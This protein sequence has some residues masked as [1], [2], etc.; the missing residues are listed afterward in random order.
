MSRTHAL[1][2]PCSITALILALALPASIAHGAPPSGGWR[3]DDI[4]GDDLLLTTAADMA[5]H[6]IATDSH[7]DIYVAYVETRD[8]G[9]AIHV[10][11]SSDGG[12]SWREWG[13][14]D[15]Y[16]PG[17]HFSDLCIV[18]G[19]G[20]YDDCV[21][22]YTRTPSTGNSA[23]FTTMSDVDWTGGD[24]NF[25]TRHAVLSQTG[26]DFKQP[27]LACDPY[28]A[29][30]WSW[31]V[32]LVAVGDDGNGSDI[33]FVTGRPDFML[34]QTT[35][36]ATLNDASREYTS[37]DVVCDTDL[38]QHVAWDYRSR[39]GAFDSALRYRR[40]VMSVWG[41]RLD[42]TTTSNGIDE[43]APQVAADVFSSD[44][45]VHIV[46]RRLGTLGLLDP[47]ELAST[48]HGESFSD[49]SIIEDGV[50]YVEDLDRNTST[51][52]W[53]LGGHLG[54]DPAM[55]IG[56]TNR[57]SD[58]A[59]FA[60]RH[61]TPANSDPCRLALDPSR[62]YR[63]MMVWRLHH[64]G[65]TADSLM[66]DA[67]WRSDPGYPNLE[68]GFPVD[69]PAAPLSA[70][71]LVDLD[72]DEDLEI[73]FSASGSRIC[74]YHHDGSVVDGWPVIVP[75][76]L[77]DG[78]VAIGDLEA[79]GNLAVV[80]GSTEGTAY[81]YDVEGNLMEGW[82]LVVPGQH[83][84]SAYVSIGAFGGP[85]PRMVAIA[86][87]T[88]L[89][90]ANARG[91]GNGIIYSWP[92]EYFHAP[93]AIGDVTGDDVA[94]AVGAVS[95]HVFAVHGADGVIVFERDLP[96]QISDALTLG[97]GIAVPLT[98]GLIYYLDGDGNDY[99]GGGWPEGTG[100]GSL[101]SV[102]FA[103]FYGDPGPD[104]VVASR[105]GWVTLLYRDGS[106]CSE[107][108]VTTGG[109]AI[110]GAP[111]AGIVAD[112]VHPSIVVGSEDA[113]GWAWA[114]D[115]DP[116]PGWPA[117]LGD[118]VHQAPAIGDLDGDGSAEIVLLSDSQ[119][120]LFGVNKPVA[121]PDQSWP[122]YGYNPQ[123]TGCWQCVENIASA[124]DPRST[125]S[126][127][128]FRNT[129]PIS[130]GTTFSYALPV[131]ARATLEVFDLLGR[132]VATVARE[133]AGPGEHA[134][135]WSGGDD[136]G[137]PLATGVYVARLQVRGPGLD[138]HPTCRVTV[139]R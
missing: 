95:A 87:G 80:V 131:R 20:Y 77:S 19:E 5:S 78:P 125:P 83:L 96:A 84:F 79:D 114:L 36:L 101:L 128:A 102:A 132:R 25:V 90:F 23:I 86:A 66:F 105:T 39:T 134:V 135:T 10:L 27:D 8:S 139:V 65:A 53:V 89:M 129:N 97:E 3:M 64:A 67:E 44:N 88:R 63:A 12:Y 33:W 124:I 47:G 37:P 115:G 117:L 120:L 48:D 130:G 74:A 41:T 104:L 52:R 57:W 29:G 93:V 18:V 99:A 107:F 68:P 75:A 28:A 109:R 138:A 46:C 70:P 62:D 50:R 59:L 6:A 21:L 56:T 110:G 69:L 35:T 40:C 16:S 71:A 119:L 116:V 81:A 94:E 45:S 73:V 26:I 85:H 91:E 31:A 17:T 14:V 1:L 92:G 15:D 136:Q 111:V 30:H 123:R 118:D 54:Y 61:Y 60:D 22:V 133:E 98:N 122:M 82:P 7:G 58:P 38:V 106:E 127:L 13:L 24:A 103:D 121:P 113:R 100:M 72:G 108:P 11:R 32:Y 112:D 2:I 43:E 51:D 137:R 34:S 126:T 76:P 42:L 55:Q 4:G 9:D 49:L